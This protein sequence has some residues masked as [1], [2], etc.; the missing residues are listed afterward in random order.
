MKNKIIWTIKELYEWAVKNNCENY[1]VYG[2]DEGMSCNL[3]I[4]E[5][6]IDNKEEE[7]YIC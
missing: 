4:D 6:I 5:I 1:T 2:Q 3:T 7:V